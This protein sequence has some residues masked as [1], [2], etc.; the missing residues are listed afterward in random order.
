[1]P[2]TKFLS[3]AVETLAKSLEITIEIFYS[4]HWYMSVS[5]WI[6]LRNSALIISLLRMFSVKQIRMVTSHKCLLVFFYQKLT[7]D[8]LKK[9]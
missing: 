9:K 6:A 3:R 7:G 4:I 1:M 8:V 5:F 2:M